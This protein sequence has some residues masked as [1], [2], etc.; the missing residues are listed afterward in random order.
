MV[1]EMQFRN[2]FNSMQEGVYLHR[3]VYDDQG[4]AV[5]YHI[6]EANPI[7][8]EYLNIKREEAIGKLA[9]DLYGT[10][11]APFID[12]YAK[13]A[14]TGE[15]ISFEQFFEPMKKYFFYFCFFARKRRICNCISGYYRKKTSRDFVN[16]SK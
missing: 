9:T 6:I 7:S 5:N 4:N 12:L 11:K 3:L 10:E 8:E 16:Q 1:S 13:V 14:E 2:L 15:P